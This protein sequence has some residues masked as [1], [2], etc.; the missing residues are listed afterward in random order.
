MPCR[1]LTFWIRGEAMEKF[2]CKL[3]IR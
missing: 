3:F 1:N 2:K